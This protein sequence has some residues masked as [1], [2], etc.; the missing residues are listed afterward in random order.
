MLPGQG[1]L[2]L[3]FP[4]GGPQPQGAPAPPHLRGRGS[5]HRRVQEHRARTLP[6]SGSA[7]PRGRAGDRAPSSLVLLFG[8][9]P[10]KTGQAEYPQ[11]NH[12]RVLFKSFSSQK[13]FSQEQATANSISNPDV[14]SGCGLASA[15]KATWVLRLPRLPAAFRKLGTQNRAGACFALQPQVSGQALRNNQK[16]TNQKPIHGKADTEH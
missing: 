6:G 10:P 11:I 7:P 15:C 16:T 12:A 2:L 8:M 3:T 5:Q 4:P 13:L 1:F 14:A 9:P